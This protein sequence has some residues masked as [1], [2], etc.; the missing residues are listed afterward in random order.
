MPPA[1][2]VHQF[3]RDIMR[4]GPLE[5]RQVRRRAELINKTEPVLSDVGDA[6]RV[7]NAR[8]R[9]VRH[10]AD[11]MLSRRI[12]VRRQRDR[13]ARQLVRVINVL[14]DRLYKRSLLR[15]GRNSTEVFGDRRAIIPRLRRSRR[16]R[17]RLGIRPRS[18]VDK[19]GDRSA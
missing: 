12:G 19:P 10:D 14:N 11:R 5:L 1:D 3:V 15:R 9:G 8:I 2:R 6:D 18:H 13:N 17:A 4:H 7:G 16:E